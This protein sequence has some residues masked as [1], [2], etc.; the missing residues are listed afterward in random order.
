M[1][2]AVHRID[3]VP[4]RPLIERKRREE[5]HAGE[6][7]RELGRAHDEPPESPDEPKGP[8]DPKGSRDHREP[9]PQQD[10]P[11]APRFEDEAG[12]AL[13]LTA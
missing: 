12:G 1:D 11:V 2:Y 9:T 4:I 13:D 8:K 10:T 3:P 5:E 6:F 7:E